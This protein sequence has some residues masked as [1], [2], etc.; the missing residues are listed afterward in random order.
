MQAVRI[1]RKPQSGWKIPW[2][3]MISRDH[4]DLQFV[5]GTLKVNL[6]E[7]AQ[8][9]IMYRG[10]ATRELIVNPGDWFQIGSTAFQVGNVFEVQPAAA[11]APPP[12]PTPLEAPAAPAAPAAPRPDSNQPQ[13]EVEFDGGPATGEERGYSPEELKQVAFSNSERQL[14]SLSTLPS[15]I[16]SSHSDEELGAMISRMLLEAIPQSEAVAVAHYDMS[17]MPTHEE[18]MEEFPAPLTMR[19]ET[20]EDFDGRFRP[21]RRMIRKALVDQVSVMH[22]WGEDESEDSSAFTMTEGLGWA[23]CS[24][25]RGESCHG[26]C[27]YVSGQGLESGAIII[28]DKDLAGDLR[29]TELVAQFIG[30]IRNVRMLQEQKTQL[31]TFFSPSVIDNLTKEGGG[32]ALAPA[33]KA[34]TVLFCD[35]RGFSR[36]SEQLQDDLLAL[37]QSVSA[38]LGVMAG[39]IIERDGAIADFQGDAV[40]GFWGWPVELKE[41]PVPACRSALSIHA[42][43]VKAVDD[44]DVLLDGFSVG[45]GLAHGR[46]LAGQIGTDKQAKV[47]VFG[48]V[49]N[50]G[51]R[52]EGM[53]KQ[54]GVPICMDET[55]A[56]FVKKYM[57]P[58]EGRLRRLASVRP[59][60]MDTSLTVYTVLPSI[61]E[62]PEVTDEFLTAWDAAVG[63]VIDGNWDQA[64]EFIEGLPADDGP[65]NFM[66]EHMS[67]SENK[68][69]E[70][71]DGAF[72]LTSK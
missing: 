49:V 43:F 29:Y 64:R 51:S 1:G 33:E 35:V 46:A 27:M 40:L 45:I 14:E 10:S 72:S 5:N 37:L 24:P 4:A 28:E 3:R 30:S 69:P 68:P 13:V 16:S 6:L 12:A 38:A 63:Q 20:R 59:K 22:I 71:W 39:N 2:D 53:T 61:D 65:R 67:R 52:L 44:H 56:E 70:G 11:P 19:V 31:S 66:L 58:A 34:I 7:N 47:G 57:P 54:F 62:L 41:G 60:G 18:Q 21:S 48:P 25:I 42:E 50:Q 17:E 26:W 8:N 9:P 36:K 23:F 55:C 32:D 15:M